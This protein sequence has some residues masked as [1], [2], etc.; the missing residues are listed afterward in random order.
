[1]QFEGGYRD[2]SEN[3]SDLENELDEVLGHDSS[4]HISPN[5]NVSNEKLLKGNIKIGELSIE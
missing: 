4:Q 2:N 1:M 5:K 3:I